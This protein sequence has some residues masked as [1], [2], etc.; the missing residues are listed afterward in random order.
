MT[1]PP[2]KLSQPGADKAPKP[3]YLQRQI[4][5]YRAAAK[6]VTPRTCPICGYHGLFQVFGTPPRYDARCGG[7][8]SL[9]RH[10]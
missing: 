3:G 1:L 2:V 6:G 10:R 8:G 4:S 7:C 9:E 5:K